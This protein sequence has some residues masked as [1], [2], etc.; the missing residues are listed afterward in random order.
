MNAKPSPDSITW[1]EDYQIFVYGANK[2]GIHGAGAA[3][4]ALKFG[5]ERGTVGSCGQTYGICTKDYNIQAMSLIEVNL[6]VAMFLKY[7][8]RVDKEFLVTAVGTGLAGL[9]TEDMAQM[10]RL[11]PD[12]VRLPQSFISAIKAK[13]VRSILRN[14]ET[15]YKGV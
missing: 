4:Q 8:E 2:A 6:E 13:L 10:F 12:N 7:A 3:K 11:A 15:A 9:P 5:A 1:L 14:A